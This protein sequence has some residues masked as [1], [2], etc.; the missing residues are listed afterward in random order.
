M[1]ILWFLLISSSVLWA[2]GQDETP[3]ETTLEDLQKLL[4][5]DL[6]N[7][8]PTVMVALMVRNKAHVLPL[9]LSYLERQDYP[10]KRMSLWWVFLNLQNLYKIIILLL[11]FYR[12]QSDYNTDD[13]LDI[14]TEWLLNVQPL[15]HSV[16]KVLD[17]TTQRHQNE[18]SPFDW[19][20]ARFDHLISLKEQAMRDAK[21][22]WADYIFVSNH[23]NSY[24]QTITL[25]CSYFIIIL[26]S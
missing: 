14:L 22:I 16:H 6:K 26:A 9:F 15:Y 25:S 10:K 17:D 4:P 20:R 3:A 24:L 8:E 7:K 19:P 12:I 18:S 13:S 11:S 5:V 1:K 21:Q 23:L 2:Y